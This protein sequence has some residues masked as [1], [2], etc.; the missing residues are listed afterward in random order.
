MFVFGGAFNPVHLGHL[1]I[2]HQVIQSYYLQERGQKILIV[3]SFIPPFKE[4]DKALLAFETRYKLL[5]LAL[6]DYSDIYSKKEAECIELSDIERCYGKKMYTSVLIQRLKSE[7]DIK[8]KVCFIAG[9]DILLELNLWHDIDYLKQNVVFVI[10]SRTQNAKINVFNRKKDG[11]CIEYLEGPI[12]DISSSQ[13]RSS[14]NVNMLSKS[15]VEYM[16]NNGLI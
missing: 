9:D 13:I 11:F 4:N 12:L 1:H 10:Y 14:N 2:I 6:K 8:E 15:C 16:R 3:P 5:L 7:S